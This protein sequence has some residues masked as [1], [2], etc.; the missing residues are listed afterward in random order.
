[1]LQGRRRK[2][3][4]DD[5]KVIRSA[6]AVGVFVLISRVLGLVRDMSMAAVFGTSLAMSAFVVAFTIPNLFRSL[7][8]EGAMSSAFVPMFAE[9]REKDGEGRGWMFANRMFSALSLVLAAIVLAGLLLARVLQRAV[10]DN[11]LLALIL[12]LLQIMLPYMFF[13]CAAAFFAAMLNSLHH[14]ALPAS[15]PAVL[16]AVLIAT[17]LWVCPRLDGDGHSRIMAVAWAVIAGGV[18]QSSMQLPLLFKHGFRLRLDF[19]RGDAA[20][21]RV[22]RLM[23]VAAVGVGV[24]QINVLLD[25]FLAAF[26]GRESPSYL[27]FSERLIYFPLG[28]FATALGTVLLPA[29]SGQAARSRTDK[30][31]EILNRSIRH[32]MFAMIPAAVGMMIL[33]RP[34]VRLIYER[35]DF[36]FL[37]TEMTM[38]ALT[39]YAPGLIMFGLLKVLVPLFYARQDMKTPVRLGLVCTGLNI[40]LS[41]ALM[42]PLG[43]IGIALA[44]V[45]C[46]TVNVL[47]LAVSARRMIGSPGWPRIAGAMLRIACAAAVMAAAAV[48]AHDRLYEA[49]FALDPSLRRGVALAGAIGLA[50]VAYV[51]AALLF[52]CPEPGEIW[53]AVKKR[54]TA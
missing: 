22:W 33:A 14:F 2:C 45:L 39:C 6:G 36:G 24:T 54:G 44:T 31:L 20:V 3:K 8:G 40:C 27:Y 29:F 26:I 35:G 51:A 4:M 21:M 38:L 30:M 23:G 5:G 7:F 9:V 42:R 32:L 53:R 48:T 37:S 19:K 15:A 1:M 47:L 34:I 52:R 28:I 46:A 18:I 41:L 11:E 10:P 25:R 16:N 12:V 43:H 13:I 17:L 50:V 49:A